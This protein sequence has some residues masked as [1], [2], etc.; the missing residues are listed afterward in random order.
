MFVY[1]R[2]YKCRKVFKPNR[3]HPVATELAWYTGALFSSED[4][5]KTRVDPPTGLHGS[6]HPKLMILWR[7]VPSTHYCRNLRHAYT[8]TSEVRNQTL[9]ISDPTRCGL[10]WGF[11]QAYTKVSEVK[12]GYSPC[13]SGHF[14]P[15]SSAWKATQR[16]RGMFALR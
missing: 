2:V 8:S 11:P 12:H 10:R 9:F 6:G 16:L 13:S 1:W 4:H 15:E 3:V 14:A 7:H 5:S